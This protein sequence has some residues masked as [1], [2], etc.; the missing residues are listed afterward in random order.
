M[1]LLFSRFLPHCA[2]TCELEFRSWWRRRLGVRSACGGSIAMMMPRARWTPSPRDSSLPQAVLRPKQV[3]VVLKRPKVQAVRRW[4][5]YQ[6]FHRVH[7]G[8][9]KLS[10]SQRRD[11]L[12]FEQAGSCKAG[13]PAHASIHLCARTHYQSTHA[14]SPD[15]RSWILRP[16][17]ALET[18]RAWLRRTRRTAA[19]Q[20]PVTHARKTT[21]V[22]GRLPDQ[23]KQVRNQLHPR[24]WPLV[25]LVMEAQAL[26]TLLV[27]IALDGSKAAAT[28]LC[29]AA[30]AR[31]TPSAALVKTRLRRRDRMT[32]GSDSSAGV[33]N[34]TAGCVRVRLCRL[35][36][37]TAHQDLQGPAIPGSA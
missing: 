26:S 9:N 28:L 8:K 12:R 33:V 3:V 19:S 18:Q 34:A 15:T 7:A 17:L 4:R 13:R 27:R 1:A 21:S 20:G 10:A 29:A 24:E 22:P 2:C 37:H 11:Q 5:L 14:A 25:L 31:F 32:S 16:G 36:W 30:G 6:G 23:C 35:R